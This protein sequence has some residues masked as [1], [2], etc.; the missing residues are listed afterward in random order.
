MGRRKHEKSRNQVDLGSELSVLPCRKQHMAGRQFQ[1]LSNPL[2]V[3]PELS[4]SAVFFK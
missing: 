2:A 1:R 3:D 4:V